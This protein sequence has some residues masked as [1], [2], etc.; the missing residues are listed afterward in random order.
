MMRRARIAV[1]I[2]AIVCTVYV[3]SPLPVMAL[4]IL[5]QVKWPE[6]VR[7]VLSKHA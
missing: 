3:F 4:A 1:A 2:A 7:N 5:A 6:R